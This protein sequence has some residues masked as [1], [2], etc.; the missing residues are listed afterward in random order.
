MKYKEQNISEYL[1]GEITK[2][3]VEYIFMVPG[4]HIVPLTKAVSNNKNIKLIIAT[5][6][7]AAAFMAIGYARTSGKIGVVMSIGGPGAAYMVGAGITAKADDVPLLVITGNIPKNNHGYGE[8]Q[9][10]SSKG[11]N[12]SA[13]FKEAIGKSI[14]C[15]Y[16]EDIL[17]VIIEILKQKTKFRPLH[18]QIPIDVQIAKVNSHIQKSIADQYRFANLPIH[19]A[20]ANINFD[21]KK[22]IVFFLGRKVLGVVNYKR[23]IE[24]AQRNEIAIVTDMKTRGIIPENYRESLGYVGFNSDYRAL[25]VLNKDSY[26]AADQIFAIGVKES[27]IKQYIDSSSVDVIRLTPLALK[28]WLNTQ[29]LNSSENYSTEERKLWIDE[30]LT[31]IPPKPVAMKFNNKVSYLELFEVINEV[32]PKETVYCLDAGQVRRAG[33]MLLEC[34]FPESLIQSDTLSP[35]GSGICAAIGAKLA[36]KE[37]PVVSIFGDGSMHMHGM[38]LATAMRYNTPIIFI[39]CDN[40]SYASTPQSQTMKDITDLPETDWISFAKSFKMKA[41]F[42]NNN[43][44]FQ[45]D[46]ENALKE[47]KPT[48][49]WVKV[50]MLLDDEFKETK[51]L[52]YKNWLTNLKDK[53]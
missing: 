25:E 50:P 12:D 40:L 38:E 30:L 47:N 48:L 26:F 28:E 23:L 13:I 19:E 21:R 36:V 20:I 29:S 44:K 22:K 5:H 49:L 8:F 4:A 11:T 9:D 46:L 2:L 45:E 27:L 42:S 16:P 34:N 39:V 31:I 1:I 35:M 43:D 10:A 33:S 17:D 3:G 53:I 32:M 37:R 41:Y 52:E 51:T 15:S 24:F 14:V 6:E 7:L 18:I